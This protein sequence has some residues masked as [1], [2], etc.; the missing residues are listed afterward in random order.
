MNR[1]S[2]KLFPDVAWL[3]AS[4]LE[5][6]FA[7]AHSFSQLPLT[8]L[9][10]PYLRLNTRRLR[11]PLELI[12][13]ILILLFPFSPRPTTEEP[14]PRAPPPK[15]NKSHL[16]LISYHFRRFVLPLFYRTIVIA[17]PEDWMM[18]FD[19]ERG[20]LVAGGQGKRRAEWVKEL[21]VF[22]GAE[23]PLDWERTDWAQP[24]I[25]FV[26]CTFPS[27]KLDVL[28]ILSKP[29]DVVPTDPTPPEI[30]AR[31]PVERREYF[32]EG[33]KADR[34][35]HVYLRNADLVQDWYACETLD[36]IEYVGRRQRGVVVWVFG[37]PTT[38]AKRDMLMQWNSEKGGR[39]LSAH[40]GYE[41]LVWRVSFGT[42]HLEACCLGCSVADALLSCFASRPG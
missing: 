38:G 20:L 13:H 17:R 10:D 26:H 41:G 15:R 34:M 18:F 35:G 6:D 24:S 5:P 9:T 8:D 3:A 11:V 12:E 28:S 29:S 2:L 1:R 31:T 25:V 40:L 14:S 42:Y 21:W 37:W 23:V 30:V 36:R 39:G 19:S 22:R 4:L 32:L 16:L 27:L 7:M 33:W